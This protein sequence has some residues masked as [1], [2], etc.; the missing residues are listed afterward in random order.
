MGNFSFAN[1]NAT[2]HNVNVRRVVDVIKVHF[3]SAHRIR[4]QHGLP[5][6]GRPTSFPRRG[7]SLLIDEPTCR[8]PENCPP[9]LC[10]CLSSSSFAATAIK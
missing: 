6:V 5:V 4:T 9:L 7:K 2:R 1:L 8:A 10:R 3:F